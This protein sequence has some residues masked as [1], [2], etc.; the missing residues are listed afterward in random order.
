M[1]ARS[2]KLAGLDLSAPNDLR[3][4]GDALLMAAL[5]GSLLL[6]PLILWKKPELVWVVPA[7]V[8][9][10]ALVV[11]LFRHPLLNLGVLLAGIVVV[12]DYEPG[13]QAREVLYGLYYLGFLAHFFFTRII[14]RGERLFRRPE[15]K[16]LALF[17]LGITA[18]IGLTILWDGDM[19]EVLS[20][21]TALVLLLLYFPVKEAFVRYPKAPVVLVVVIGWIGVFAAVRNL[22]VYQAILSEASQLWQ[23]ARNRVITNDGLLMVSALTM[24]VALLFTERWMARIAMLGVFLVVFAGLILTQS[25]GFWVGF[26][27]G[28]FV[29]LVALKRRHRIRLITF[30]SVSAAVA[31]LVGFAFFKDYMLL[32]IGGLGARFGTLQ[33]AVTEDVSLVNRFIESGAVLEKI[34]RNPIAGYGMGVPFRM[35]DMTFTATRE[36]TFIHNGYISVWYRFG[37]WGLGCL[38]VVYGATVLR[39]ARSLRGNIE[40]LTRICGTAALVALVAY[41]LPAITSNPFHLND[42]LFIYG[43]LFGMAAGAAERAQLQA[44]L[45]EMSLVR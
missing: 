24:L 14:L 16:A 12:S 18:S 37:L 31:V 20:Q 36:D 30:V 22:L 39:A 1:S 15:E 23:V 10:G 11:A 35:Y 45:D 41:S 3:K 5:A 2:L 8:V 25:R 9:A 26:L 21:W 6:L 27:V 42:G 29:L 44:P 19:K 32:I 33:T 38:L 13:I 40:V 7:I 34:Y 28:S 4:L 43:V 17:M